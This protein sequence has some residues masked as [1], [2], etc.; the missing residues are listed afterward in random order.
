MRDNKDDRRLMELAGQIIRWD[1]VD[2]NQIVDVFNA[3]EDLLN[4]HRYQPSSFG[5]TRE[6]IP[7][8][9]IP[10]LLKES[11]LVIAVD[12][13]KCCIFGDSAP[14]KVMSIDKLKRNLKLVKEL[15]K[16]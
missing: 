10:K 12:K 11:S 3:F 16:L 13:N 5:I 2:A 8:A 9:Y 14:Y 1:K 6:T 4:K 7:S 15:K